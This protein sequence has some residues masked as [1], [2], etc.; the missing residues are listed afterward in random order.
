LTAYEALAD[1]IP[2]L[3]KSRRLEHPTGGIALEQVGN[4]CYVSTSA[5]VILD[6]E[7]KF[8]MK[9]ISIW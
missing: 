3:A 8:L 2:N 5:R 9:L 6:L 4:A 1:F 7:E